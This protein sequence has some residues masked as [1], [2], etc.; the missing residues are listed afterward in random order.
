MKAC[1][2]IIPRWRERSCYLHSFFFSSFTSVVICRA[3]ITSSDR[4]SNLKTDTLMSIFHPYFWLQENLWANLVSPICRVTVISD[5]TVSLSDKARNGSRKPWWESKINCVEIS[6]FFQ[7][8]LSGLSAV[9]S[10]YPLS[11]RWAV[12]KFHTSLTSVVAGVAAL[13]SRSSL[14]DLTCVEKRG[15]TLEKHCCAHSLLPGC[16]LPVSVAVNVCIIYIHI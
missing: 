16:F 2:L 13:L 8:L 7:H 9:Q 4:A 1:R 6:V 3:W 10:F 11:H 15:C 5:L 12:K 14:Q